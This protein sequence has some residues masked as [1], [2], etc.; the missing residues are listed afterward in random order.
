MALFVIIVIDDFARVAAARYVLL[1]LTIVGVGSIDPNGRCGAFSGTMIS[2]IL[3]IVLFLLL[4]SFFG[5]FSAIRAL[6]S[7]G[8]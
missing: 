6:R 5:A 1:L 4:P 2:F 7:W 3:A 8:C